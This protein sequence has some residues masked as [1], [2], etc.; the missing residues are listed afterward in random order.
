MVYE[1]MSLEEVINYINFEL[2]KGRTMKDIE[3]IDFNV[4]ER[5]ITKRL[6]RKKIKKVNGQFVF[7]NGSKKPEVS[8]MQ[9]TQTFSNPI[10]NNEPINLM[11]NREFLD[12]SK[13]VDILE[14][15]FK[16]IICIQNSSKEVT[17]DLGLKIYSSKDKPIAKTIRLYKEVWDKIDKVKDQFPHIN[18]QTLLNS[19][20]DEITEKYLK[21]NE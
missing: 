6:A 19:L 21:N 11:E 4:N 5:V 3:E 12:L 7:Q 10:I 1:D 2:L 18:Y 17:H 14:K 13:K 16:E 9:V 8:S 20:I 15:A